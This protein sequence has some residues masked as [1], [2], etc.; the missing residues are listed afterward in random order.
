[1]NVPLSV[2]IE[3]LSGSSTLQ[4]PSVLEN[5]QVMHDDVEHSSFCGSQL[6]VGEITPNSFDDTMLYVVDEAVNARISRRSYPKH[7]LVI[8]AGAEKPSAKP[9]HDA[10]ISLAFASSKEKPESIFNAVTQC[11]AAYTAWD[12]ELVGAILAS[13]GIDAVL[14]IAAKALVNPIAFFDTGSALVAQSGELPSGYEET[15]WGRVVSDGASPMDY[16]TAEE[17]RQLTRQLEAEPLPVILTPERA[18]Q[19]TNLAALVKTEGR[20]RGT[21]GQVDL[22]APFTPAQIALA[23]HVRMRLQQLFAMASKSGEDADELVPVIARMLDGYTADR[24]I[25]SFHLRKRVWEIE[26]RYRVTVCPIPQGTESR[27]SNTTR[28]RNIGACFSDALL[29]VHDGAV[30][31]LEHANATTG[32]DPLEHSKFKNTLASFNMNAASSIWFNSLADIVVYYRQ[33]LICL[34]EAERAGLTGVIAYRDIFESHIAH[35]ISSN[36]PPKSICHPAVFSLVT[37]G[38][39]GDVEQGRELVEQLYVF[40]ASGRN[41]H[42]CAR[43]LFVHHNT[44]AYRIERLE[45]LLDVDLS[46]LSPSEV[47][48]LELS[49]LLALHA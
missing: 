19:H 31:I 7:A 18:P 42:R 27:I 21:I 8:V 26:S 24:S 30:I 22:I 48:H 5:A 33:A 12:D 17:Q 14:D 23:Q 46:E 44:L 11:L 32:K 6:A 45:N 13:R 15:I 38:Y 29:F 20:A 9:W 34:A 35:L 3:S 39:K 25:L 28:I 49:C 37:D 41:V 10:C 2:I 47:V 4:I 36:V 40:L 1:M 16:Y 43:L